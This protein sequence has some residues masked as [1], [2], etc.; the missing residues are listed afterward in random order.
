MESEPE[1]QDES[2]D[3]EQRRGDRVQASRGVRGLCSVERH[4]QHADD[5]DCSGDQPRSEAYPP[6][7]AEPLP[8]LTEIRGLT[9]GELSRERLEPHAGRIGQRADQEGDAQRHQTQRVNSG[10]RDDR[11]QDEGQRQQHGEDVAAER[12]SQVREDLL[13][14]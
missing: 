11:H 4:V 13:A 8:L 9:A 5:G 10:S 7:H 1:E 12:L 2:P 6:V 3:D 14:G